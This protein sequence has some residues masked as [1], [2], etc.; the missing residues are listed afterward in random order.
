MGHASREFSMACDFYSLS[1]YLI[2][3][4]ALFGGR[5]CYLML[6]LLAAK[7]LPYFPTTF[8]REIGR[9]IRFFQETCLQNG[10]EP[11]IK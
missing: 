11:A 3:V 10:V 6:C 8:V 4:L 5:E 1:F 9:E 2:N 7:L